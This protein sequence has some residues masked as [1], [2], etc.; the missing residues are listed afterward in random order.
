MTR[1]IC[2]TVEEFEYIIKKY[3]EYVYYTDYDIIIKTI[4]EN[5]FISLRINQQSVSFFNQQSV[6]FCRLLCTNC[7]RIG[8][9]NRAND[10]IYISN[11]MRKEKLERILND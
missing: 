6:S 3:N 5:K 9:I 4:N 2:T 11:L 7:G 8:C 10:I 1:Y